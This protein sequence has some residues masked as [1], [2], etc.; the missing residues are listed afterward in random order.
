MIVFGSQ[1]KTNQ[2][3][4]H[5][6]RT[7]KKELKFILKHF[8]RLKKLLS[9]LKTGSILNVSRSSELKKICFKLLINVRRI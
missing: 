2:Q 1:P 4:Q 8:N 7:E 3:S 9:S 5:M 6:H